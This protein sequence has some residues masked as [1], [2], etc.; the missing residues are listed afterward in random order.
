MNIAELYT[1]RQGEG[2]LTGT[3]SVFIRTSGCN[4]R[5]RFCDTP[6]TSWHPRGQ[7]L[8]VNEIVKQVGHSPARHVVITGGEPLIQPDLPEL[9]ERL[10][11]AGYHLTIE[12]AGTVFT[13]LVCDLVSLSPKLANSDPDPATFRWWNA[14]HARLRLNVPV[15]QAWL[16]AHL[17][18]LKFV[19]DTPDDLMEIDA[20]L[21]Q[22]SGCQPEQVWLMPQGVSPERLQAAATWLLPACAE[23]GYHYCPRMHLTWYGHRRGS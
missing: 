18:Q 3:E 12:T 13:N 5:C 22:L 15:L 6:Y 19:V 17:C 10:H 23:R 4:L 21:K 2:A 20:L 16:T 1:S 11:T 14:R 8:T 9:T 7:S